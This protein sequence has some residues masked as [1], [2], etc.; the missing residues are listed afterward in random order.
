MS[1]FRIILLCVIM[2]AMVTVAVLTY[3][4]IASIILVMALLFVVPVWFWQKYLNR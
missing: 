4:S 1:K 2:A 3:P